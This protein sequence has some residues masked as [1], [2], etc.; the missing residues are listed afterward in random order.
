M[1]G[2][3][4]EAINEL[5]RPSVKPY[6][7]YK[8][9]DGALTLGNPKNYESA[10]SIEVERYFLTKVARPPAATTV[11]VKTEAD[12]DTQSTLALDPMEGIEMGNSDFSK[13]QSTRVYTVIDANAPGGKLEVGFDQLEKGYEYG[14]TAVHISEF[15]R[16]ITQL[17]TAKG[18]SIVGFISQDNVRISFLV[19]VFVSCSNPC[20][21]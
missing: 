12:G 9:Y 16:N 6:R 14:R 18:L 2:T 11:V 3:V 20:L 21:V 1:F 17:K 19:G 13:V 15:D 10:L 4:A 8:T 7:P 5:D